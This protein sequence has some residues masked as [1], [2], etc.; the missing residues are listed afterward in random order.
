MKR[1]TIFAFS[2]VIA[3]IAVLVIRAETVFKSSQMEPVVLKAQLAIDESAAIQRFS[4]AINFPTVS[5]DDRSNFDADTFLA[6]H[7]YLEQSYPLVHQHMER[8]VVNDYSLV[9]ELSGTDPSLKPVLFM[10][11]MDVVPIDP[12]SRDEWTHDPFSGEVSD[13]K[14]WGRGTLDDKIGVISLLEAMESLLSKNRQIGRTIYLAFGHDEEVGGKDGAAKIAD[15]FEDKDTEFDLVLDEGGFVTEG[16]IAEVSQPVAIIG[17]AEKGWVNLELVVNSSGGHSSQP[18]AHSAVGILSAAIVKVENHAFPVNIDFLMVTTDAIGTYMPFSSRFFLGNTWLFSFLIKDRLLKTPA[19]AASIRTTT[20][21][22]MISGSPKSNILPTRA[23]A[24]VNFRIIPG[25]T[26][27]SVKESIENAINDER[28]EV[29][30]ASGWNPSPVSPTDSDG[31]TQIARTIRALDS[32]VLVAPY[33]VQGGTDARYFNKLSPNVYR[34][35]MVRIQADTIQRVH[36]I[37]EHIPVDDYLD[38]IRFYYHM[39][40]QLRT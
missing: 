1:K 38:A 21:A 6:F 29:S 4:G 5:Y 20:A 11:H 12:V 31:Y 16:V 35:V 14:I 7:R 25:E 3:L 32:E 34:F 15:F 28:V 10:S 30:I 17:I 23:S 24:I 13:E 19:K 36:G 22:T 39:I 40:D 2:A 8:T 18:P 26:V 33:L 37:N 9:Y 27:E